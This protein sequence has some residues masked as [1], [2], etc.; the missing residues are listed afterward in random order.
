M[1]CQVVRHLAKHWIASTLLQLLSIIRKL[2]I[3]LTM[4]YY[5]QCLHIV[6][7]CF[8]IW[9]LHLWKYFY[10]TKKIYSES[11]T[12][13]GEMYFVEHEKTYIKIICCL[14]VMILLL[15]SFLNP[16]DVPLVFLCIIIFLMSDFWF[17]LNDQHYIKHRLV[18][19]ILRSMI[20]KGDLSRPYQLFLSR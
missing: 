17:C 3:K 20:G 15:I 18:L 10:H 12:K 7:Q 6:F 16:S 8:H 4:S 2:I 11:V 13:Y 19:Q 9:W 5:S 1:H 14:Q